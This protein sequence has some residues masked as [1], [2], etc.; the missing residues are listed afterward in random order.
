MSFSSKAVFGVELASSKRAR[1]E[2]SL[3]ARKPGDMIRMARDG[4]LHYAIYIGKD[5]VVDFVAD[6]GGEIN[7]RNLYETVGASECAIDNYLDNEYRSYPEQ[8]IVQRALYAI[9]ESHIYRL[10]TYNCEHFATWCRY[11]Y[12]YCHQPCEVAATLGALVNLS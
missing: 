11:G 12:K 7:S 1:I 2:T 3:L 5:K 8:E 10:G 6:N 4:F 9:A